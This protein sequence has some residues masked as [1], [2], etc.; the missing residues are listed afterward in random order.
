MIKTS[1]P[2]HQIKK[3]TAKKQSEYAES[4]PGASWKGCQHSERRTQ[5]VYFP[6]S[7]HD[8]NPNFWG[9]GPIP[10]PSQC[11][12][13]PSDPMHMIPQLHGRRISCPEAAPRTYTTGSCRISPFGGHAA[14]PV[15]G[16]R[17][18]LRRE[19]FNRLHMGD[20]KRL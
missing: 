5:F 19:E 9:P 16:A 11:S 10:C 7:E 14:T 17:R 6:E 18:F 1:D 13:G 15:R 12:A 4:E 2:G 8:L 20:F 3:H